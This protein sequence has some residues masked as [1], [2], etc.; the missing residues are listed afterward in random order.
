[1]ISPIIVLPLG[2]PSEFFFSA[3]SSFYH[4][5]RRSGRFPKIS[6]GVCTFI[7]ERFERKRTPFYRIDPY[8][9]RY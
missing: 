4:T 5:E 6:L 8:F 9:V 7:F 1:M 3:V 2:G